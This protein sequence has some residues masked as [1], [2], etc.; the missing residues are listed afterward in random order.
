LLA[1]TAGVACT[2]AFGS[3]SAAS[4]ANPGNFDPPS[5]GTIEVT[6]YAGFAPICCSFGPVTVRVGGVQAARIRVEIG[7]LRLRTLGKD[8][9]MCLENGD[10]F[11][12]DFLPTA[13]S[14]A[15]KVDW[16]WCGRRAGYLTVSLRGR[17]FWL[18]PDCALRRTLLSVLP[19]GKAAFTRT[20][21]AAESRAEHCS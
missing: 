1:V 7:R 2:V 8:Q 15:V 11:T 21:A 20:A 9:F 16:W 17:T 6:G 3:V 4:A 18:A 14:D 5:S 13:A 12:I 19:R 10:V